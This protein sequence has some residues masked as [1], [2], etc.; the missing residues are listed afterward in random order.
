MT[1]NCFRDDGHW[2]IVKSHFKKG[3][4]FIMQ[5]GHNDQKRR[6]LAAF[7]GYIN[8]L[9]WFVNEVRKLGGFPVIVSPI[10]RVP[11]VD[12][13]QYHSLLETHALACKQA[14]MEM[15]VPF[16]DLH[17][18][19][20]DFLC[21]NYDNASD[22][23]I[24]GD[25]THTN[26]YGAVKI[27]DLFT[28]SVV[29]NKIYPLADYLNSS[30]TEV[31]NSFDREIMPVLDTPA[32]NASMPL[33]YIDI[34]GIPQYEGIKKAMANGLLDPCVLHLHPYDVMPRG[35]FLMVMFK[36]LRINGK[37]PYLGE[38]CDVSRYEWDSAYVQACID[39]GLIDQT[40]V[41]GG[42]FRPDDPLT[43][44]EFASFAI[45]GLKDNSLSIEKSDCFKKAKELGIIDINAL[46]DEYIVRADCYV[47]LVKVMELLDN[48]S[49][50]LPSDV[51]VHPVG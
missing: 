15:G 50:S 43:F 5:F 33:P 48:S 27:A 2:D 41:S 26:E 17:T 46:P 47:G 1:T 7:G 6:N 24:K 18:M 34:E 21:E 39:E 44:C 10:S 40:T 38:F 12:Q 49:Q 20:F 23:F 30:Y 8:N 35:Q 14:A 4:I 13:G 51:E 29:K 16:I 9:R 25:I 31:F 28:D 45:R 42:R 36:A 3:D 32:S 11:I 22:Y 37:R 19:T